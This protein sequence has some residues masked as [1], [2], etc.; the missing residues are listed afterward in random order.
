MSGVLYLPSVSVVSESH[1]LGTG[2]LP[3]PHSIACGVFFHSLVWAP[4]CLD[5]SFFNLRIPYQST[6]N[7]IVI[8]SESFRPDQHSQPSGPACTCSP[9]ECWAVSLRVP[10]TRRLEMMLWTPKAFWYDLVKFRNCI[11]CTC[12]ALKLLSNISLRRKLLS[13]FKMQCKCPW[14]VLSESS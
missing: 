11:N 4:T 12:T 1:S 13:V 5:N 2:Q 14:R 9:S 10:V 3:A 8:S 7:I 6:Q